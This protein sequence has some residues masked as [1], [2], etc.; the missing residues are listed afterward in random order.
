MANLLQMHVRDSI[1]HLRHDLAGIRFIK[2]VAAL[3]NTLY[4]VILV[5]LQLL[6]GKIRATQI[7]GKI[8][9]L[10]KLQHQVQL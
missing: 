4:F 9:A 1:E 2:A 5:W 8:L 10:N 7:S 6:E 3:K